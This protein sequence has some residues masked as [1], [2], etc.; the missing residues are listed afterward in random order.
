MAE[1]IIVLFV[2]NRV[3]LDDGVGPAA[4]DFI[5]ENFDLPD[6]VDLFDVGC[7]SMDMVDYVHTYDFMVTVDAVDGSPEEPG[8]VFR[9][10]PDD[11]ARNVGPT[12][13]IHDLKL[14]DLFDTASLLGYAAEGI[15]YGM[16]VGNMNPVEYAIG[17]T[18][19]VRAKLPYLAEC[20]LAEL[21]RHGCEVRHKD[22]R[23]FGPGTM[24][25]A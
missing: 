10:E 16:Q 9:Y 19:P 20:V 18:E 24:D 3:M 21:V 17:L 22:G 7:M 4:Y 6:N 2:G 11:V 8:T 23:L 25:E 13:S 5:R 14:A 12:A 15:C 1:K